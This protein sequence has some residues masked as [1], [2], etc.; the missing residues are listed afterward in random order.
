MDLNDDDEWQLERQEMARMPEVKGMKR[1]QEI[2]HIDF[3]RTLEKDKYPEGFFNWLQYNSHIWEQFERYGISMANKRIRYSARTIIEVMRWNSDIKD[4][5]S[6]LF[7]LS[8]NMTP[9]LARLWMAKHG[10]DHPTFFQ[11]NNS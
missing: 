7:K 8:N 3:L 9:G 1:L 4:R 11:L 5:H 6:K 2:L 10:L